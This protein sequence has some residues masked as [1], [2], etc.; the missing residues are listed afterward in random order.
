MTPGRADPSA[1]GRMQ[2]SLRIRQSGSTAMETSFPKKRQ[3]M[4]LKQESGDQSPSTPISV[5]DCKILC[6]M[7]NQDSF[8]QTNQAFMAR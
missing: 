8:P 7:R 6:D 2:T 4:I 5:I 3:A 1:N